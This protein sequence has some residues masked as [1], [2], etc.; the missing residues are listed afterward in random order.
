MFD[1]HT[2]I[3]PGIDDGA[4]DMDTSLAMLAMAADSGTKNIVL[5][6]HFIEGEWLPDWDRIV[7]G[8]QRL[9]AAARERNLPLNLYPGAEIAIHYDNL[10]RLKG[11]GPYCINGGCYALV[12]LPATH[13]PHY[14]DEFLFVLQARGITPIIAHAERHPEIA[15]KPDVLLAWIRK[16]ALVQMN[17]PSL[18]G[19]MGDKAKAAA[20][21]LLANN[22]VH[23][24]GSDG[25]GVNF[26]RPRLDQAV[27]RI[28]ELVGADRTHRILTVNPRAIVAGRRLEIEA[29]EQIQTPRH[30]FLHS[31]KKRLWG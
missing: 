20:E 21:L 18:I 30:S 11:P 31:V 6:P 16:G 29:P 9:Q 2:H 19:R 12:E 1:I 15:R 4:K 7:S 22:L 26:R 3:L 10:E 24:I 14:I 17:A 5:T 25:H 27:R 13:I 8:C 28:S 23:V